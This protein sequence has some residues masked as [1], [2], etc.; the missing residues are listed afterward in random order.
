MYITLEEYKELYE[1]IEEH[2]FNLLLFDACRVMDI[3]TTGIDNV[4]K[5]KLYYP[6]DEDSDKAIKYCASKLINL[7][8]QIREAEM[9][10]MLGSGFENTEHGVRGKVITSVTAG[11]ESISYSTGAGSAST[12][13]ESAAR[14]R[15][16]RNKLLA[17]I[18]WDCLSGITDANGV[19]LLYM[20]KYPRRR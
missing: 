6:T 13:A 9:S 8:H 1:P 5:L 16:V 3:H 14:D 10:M 4:K 18:V 12:A 15:T 20:G 7:L 17:D 19:N 11:N 2:V